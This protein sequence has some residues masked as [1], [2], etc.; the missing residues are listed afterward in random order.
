[1]YDSGPF[2]EHFKILLI[3][4]DQWFSDF[5]TEINKFR[6]LADSFSIGSDAAKAKVQLELIHV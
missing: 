2:A 6:F 1:M 4:F 5:Q 3:L